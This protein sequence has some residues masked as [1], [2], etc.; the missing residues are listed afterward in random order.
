MEGEAAT[1]KY[2]RE[3]QGQIKIES[4]LREKDNKEERE[5]KT[6]LY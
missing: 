2:L 1:N 4:L 3:N 6:I 5:S